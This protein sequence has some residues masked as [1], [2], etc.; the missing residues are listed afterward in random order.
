MVFEDKVSTKDKFTIPSPID[1][2]TT[3]YP[4]SI[5]ATAPST[6]YVDKTDV[7]IDPN[8]TGTEH[9]HLSQQDTDDDSSL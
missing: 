4:M 7:I 1:I 6:T 8:A 9:I 5:N 2:N 3:E